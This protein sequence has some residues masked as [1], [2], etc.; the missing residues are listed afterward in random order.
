MMEKLYNVG[1]YGITIAEDNYEEES[2]QTEVDLSQDTFSLISTEIDT[3]ELAQDKNKLKSLIK[4]IFI[5]SQ[6]R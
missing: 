6:H 3:M 2:T 1:V 4:D 5:E